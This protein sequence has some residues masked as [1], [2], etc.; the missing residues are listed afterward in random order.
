M[1]LYKIKIKHSIH[2]LWIARMVRSINVFGIYK[3]WKASRTFNDEAIVKHLHHDIHVLKSIGAMNASIYDNFV[4]SFL[5]VL[6]HCVELSVSA[7]VR[8]FS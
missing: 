5:R 6:S 2:K 4:P 7:K 3:R 1:A 8:E